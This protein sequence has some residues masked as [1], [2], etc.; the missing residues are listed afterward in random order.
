MLKISENKLTRK[1]VTLRLEGRIVG[2]W[3]EE[4]KLVCEPLLK[5][6]GRLA[7]DLAEVS[8]VDETGVAALTGLSAQGTKLLNITPFVEKQLKAG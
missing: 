4:L 1:A 5:S 6:D 2:P 7:L 3:V 8:F